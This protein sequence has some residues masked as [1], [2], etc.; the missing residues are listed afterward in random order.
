MD[1]LY[2]Y[3]E[4]KFLGWFISRTKMEYRLYKSLTSELDSHCLSWFWASEALLL[5]DSCVITH[6][7]MPTF[8][9][10][11]SLDSNWSQHIW[12]YPTGAELSTMSSSTWCFQWVFN[13][14]GLHIH[15]CSSQNQYWIIL[16]TNWPTSTTYTSKFQFQYTPFTYCTVYPPPIPM[17]IYI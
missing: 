9:G 1:F 14:L 15:Y 17:I 12:I 5:S 16:H 10:T 11:R 4:W 8:R 2:C 6:C 3:S 13:V 7:C